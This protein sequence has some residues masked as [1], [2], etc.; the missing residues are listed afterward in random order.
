[1]WIRSLRST[2]QRQTAAP[3]LD[4]TLDSLGIESSPPDFYTSLVAALPHQRVL[5]AGGSR[6]MLVKASSCTSQMVLDT[7]RYSHHS[8]SMEQ[9]PISAVVTA[10]PMSGISTSVCVVVGTQ[11]GVVHILH[12]ATD[13]SVTLLPPVPLACGPISCLCTTATQTET[14]THTSRVSDK[15]YSDGTSTPV[16]TSPHP[17]TEGERVGSVRLSH[18]GHRVTVPGHG[19]RVGLGTTEGRVLVL[20]CPHRESVV[21]AA[22]VTICDAHASSVC[23]VL[24][25]QGGRLLMSAGNDKCVRSIP[26]PPPVPRP[27]THMETDRDRDTH[28]VGLYSSGRPSL[29]DEAQAP[30]PP[31][32]P[33]PILEVG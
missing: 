19:L 18:P 10:G 5:V 17:G 13:S 24:F 12:I 22:L 23:S 9:D 8:A 4:E 11:G 26:V 27:C 25:S 15:T 21:G 31:S 16:Y 3:L 28:P 30:P 32:T 14:D 2:I 20:D 1:E 7:S 33:D 6:L 29:L